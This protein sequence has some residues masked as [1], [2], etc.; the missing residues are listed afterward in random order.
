MRMSKTELKKEFDSNINKNPTIGNLECWIWTGRLNPGGYGQFSKGTGTQ[1]LAH[2][3]SWILNKGEIPAGKWVLHKCD[4]RF[5]VNPKH[6]F[7]GTP[8][9]NL[10]DAHKKKRVCLGEDS[11]KAKLTDK[12]IEECR[13]K[14]KNGR[15]VRSLIIEY[16][17]SKAAMHK[18]VKYKTRVFPSSERPQNKT[19][20]MIK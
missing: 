20:E 16:G 10:V 9:D 15:T 6:L 5:C 7:L 2:R 12:Q 19:L 3:F 1:F 13:N 17:S 18:I 4:N 11:H 8:K 14:H